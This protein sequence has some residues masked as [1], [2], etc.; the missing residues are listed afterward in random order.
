MYT[1]KFVLI[2]F[3]AMGP[4]IYA[5]TGWARRTSFV[6]YNSKQSQTVLAN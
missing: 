6:C 2:E 3:P 4:E 5:A 1:N